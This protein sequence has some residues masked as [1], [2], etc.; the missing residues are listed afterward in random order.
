LTGVHSCVVNLWCQEKK[1]SPK[2]RTPFL[3]PYNGPLWI[4]K[5]FSAEEYLL[6]WSSHIHQDQPWFTSY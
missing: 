6:L 1:M 5:S 3:R 2:I 4:S